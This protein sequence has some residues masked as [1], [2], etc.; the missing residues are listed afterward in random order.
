MSQVIVFNPLIENPV[1][2]SESVVNGV[3]VRNYTFE[4]RSLDAAAE[5]E[6][7]RAGGTYAVAVDGD[8]LVRYRL[9][10]E[11]RT[12]PEGDPAAESSVFVVEVSLEQINQPIEITFPPGCPAAE[13]PA[14]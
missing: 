5:V 2:V 10:L 3:P 6:A 8:Y 4:L 7:T 9:D 11:L 13:I 14:G 12:G 1:F